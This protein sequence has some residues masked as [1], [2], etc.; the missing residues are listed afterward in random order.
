MSL[1]GVIGAAKFGDMI[2][3]YKQ[4]ECIRFV[5]LCMSDISIIAHEFLQCPRLSTPVS[6]GSAWEDE[7]LK[8]WFIVVADN[9]VKLTA[10]KMQSMNISTQ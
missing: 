5:I 4:I 1:S 2:I 8:Y 9:S 7:L 6:H 3:M 10:I